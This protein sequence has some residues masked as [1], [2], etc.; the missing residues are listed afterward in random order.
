[1]ITFIYVALLKGSSLEKKYNTI[2][3][4]LVLPN[5]IYY[6]LYNIFIYIY[7][8][9]YWLVPSSLCFDRNGITFSAD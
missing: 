2:F 6:Y 5:P 7:I 9:L 4:S 3:Y 1:M 8:I